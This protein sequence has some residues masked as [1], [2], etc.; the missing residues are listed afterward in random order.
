MRARSVYQASLAALLA[1]AAALPAGIALADSTYVVKPGDTLYGIAARTGSTVGAL[2]AANGIANPNLIYVGQSLTV[3]G[4]GGSAA[5]APAASP[6]PSAPPAAVEPAA[7]GSIL[8]NRRIVTYYGNPWSDQMGILGEL[9]PQ[10]LVARLKRAARLYEEAGSKRPVQPAIE[11]IA[12]VAQAGPG[13]DGMYRLRMPADEI[14]K[15]SKL[16]ADNGMLLILD[17]QVGR[18]T[19]QAELAPLIPFLKQPHVHLALD[20]EFDMWGSQVPGQQIGHITPEEIHYAQN[21]LSN[22]VAAQG[23]PNKILIVHQFTPNMISN[24][25]SIR[26]DPRVDLAIIMD[27][28]GGRAVKQNHYRLFVADDH[29]RFGGIKLFF[30]HDPNMFEPADVLGLDPSPDVVIYQ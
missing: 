22:I 6:A 23:G 25:A 14:E 2:T 16:A 29:L 1:L 28:F 18:S 4:S 27:G 26:T 17:V 3:P 8:A 9:D 19:V 5:A 10:T 7:P 24:K 15:Y 13:S 11:F 30:K 21:L 20:P 12:T